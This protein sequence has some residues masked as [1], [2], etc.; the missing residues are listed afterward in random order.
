M[1]LDLQGRWRLQFNGEFQAC[2]LAHISFVGAQQVLIAK[3]AIHERAR[4]EDSRLSLQYVAM[5][6]WKHKKSAMMETMRTTTVAPPHVPSS[7]H[8]DVTH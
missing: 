7:E 6:W 2:P 1:K 3:R 4:L 5:A 8:F